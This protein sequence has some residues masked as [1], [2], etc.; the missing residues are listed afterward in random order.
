LWRGVPVI[1]I[2]AGDLD[3]KGRERLNSGVQRRRREE[4]RRP[5][6]LAFA[7]SRPCSTRR[8]LITTPRAT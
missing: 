1:V 4:L 2:T 7:H 8:G 6:P 3:A 5:L